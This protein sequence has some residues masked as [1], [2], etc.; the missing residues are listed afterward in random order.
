MDT[1]TSKN[2][3]IRSRYIIQERLYDSSFYTLY[4]GWDSQSDRAVYIAHISPALA[5]PTNVTVC[6]ET[7]QHYLYEP[8][9]GVFH[10]MDMAYDGHDLYGIYY[11][12]GEPL[13]PLE[14]YVKG[15]TNDPESSDKRMAL[16]RQVATILAAM[17]RYHRPFA[18]FDMATIFVTA[19]GRVVLGPPML[20]SMGFEWAAGQVDRLPAAVFFAPEFLKSGSRNTLTDVY[21]FG[22]LAHYLVTLQYPYPKARTI[23]GLKMALMRGPDP[24]QRV[25]PKVSDNLNFFIMKCLM[26]DPQKRW[27]SFRT[28]ESVL[29]GKAPIQPEPLRYT[30]DPGQ[31]F[32]ADIRLVKKKR[33]LRYAAVVLNVVA[34]MALGI[35][36]YMAYGYYFTQYDVVT[37]PN[38]AGMPLADAKQA[39]SDLQLRV[40]Q[41]TYNHHSQVP[42]GHVIRSEPPGGRHIKQGRALTMVVSKGQQEVMVPSLI[43]KSMADVPVIL[44]GSGITVTVTDEVPSL[45]VPEGYIVS[46]IPL[47]NQYMFDTGTIQVTV[48]KG[49]PMIVDDLGLLDDDFRNVRVSFE[50]PQT[51]AMS[52][53]EILEKTADQQQHVLADEILSAGDYF[54]QVFII[55]QA[56]TIGIRVNGETW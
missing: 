31:G 42:D 10:L 39:V 40:A 55:H 52:R 5:T 12:A 13:V 18:G 36:G 44:G 53:V 6:L 25:N 23:L 37:V 56:S 14:T 41:V 4:E 20:V 34:V 17:E 49:S 27:Q 11:H 38:M 46:Q 45:T 8:I 22:V 35:V 32:D 50:M 21:G 48:S 24:C 2:T 29:T 7:W 16:L 30:V 3:A 33:R 51:A 43:R 28:I 19:Q 54:Q 15:L 9:E 47:P 26:F 1:D